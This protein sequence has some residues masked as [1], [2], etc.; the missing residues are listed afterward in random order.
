MCG[1]GE[2]E[3]NEHGQEEDEEEDEGEVYVGEDPGWARTRGGS[4][5]RS[6]DEEED[7]NG[8]EDEQDEDE[9][10]EEQQQQQRGR[11]MLRGR[12]TLRPEEQTLGGI[13]K[14]GFMEP[15]PHLKMK[16]GPDIKPRKLRGRK[17]TS[18][19]TSMITSTSNREGG[20]DSR[21]AV[22]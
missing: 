12:A 5:S 19:I 22:D 11:P 1:D 7:K 6:G 17:G 14:D 21:M 18:T 2:G 20:E 10:E 13:R 8:A 15:V 4:G 16:R 3:G 9:E